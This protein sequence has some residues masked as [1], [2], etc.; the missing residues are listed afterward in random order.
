MAVIEFNKNQEL[1]PCPSCGSP[2]VIV[3]DSLYIGCNSVNHT[4]SAHVVCTGCGFRTPS[5]EAFL[6]YNGMDGLIDFWN[7]CIQKIDYPELDIKSIVK[8]GFV[9]VKKL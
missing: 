8:K 2:A 7:S 1:K 3:I 6:T 4:D 5:F 9:D